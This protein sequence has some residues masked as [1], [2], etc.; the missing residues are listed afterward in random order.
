MII[1]EK[2]NIHMYILGFKWNGK[3]STL[4]EMTKE[5]KNKLDLNHLNLYRSMRTDIDYIIWASAYS[6]EPFFT[7][8][9]EMRKLNEFSGIYS[10]FSIYEKSPYIKRETPVEKQINESTKKYFIAYPMSKSTEWYLLDYDVRKKIM[11]EHISMAMS[12]PNNNGILSYTTY[13]FGIGDQEFVVMYEAD[14]LEKWMKVTEKLRESVS[15]RWIVKE[16]PILVGLRL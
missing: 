1:K 11:K 14:D 9:A 12:D 7:L 13:S 10:Y 8:I 4:S 6:S 16:T 15:R 3:E 5:I 2:S